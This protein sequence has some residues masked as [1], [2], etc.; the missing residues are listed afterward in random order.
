MVDDLPLAALPLEGGDPLGLQEWGEDERS[1]DHGPAAIP[2]C[3][4]DPAALQPDGAQPLEEEALPPVADQPWMEGPDDLRW[5]QEE[6][7]GVLIQNEGGGRFAGECRPG[8]I[9]FVDRDGYQAAEDWEPP[10][11]P[12]PEAPL[13]PQG[14][15]GPVP[16]GEPWDETL[17]P[18]GKSTDELSWGQWYEA[19]PVFAKA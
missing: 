9:N 8:E 15:E 5:I 11:A 12:L 7:E 1:E 14:M 19:C 18:A 6:D 3:F 17:V 13:N 4:L 10:E 16:A 2:D